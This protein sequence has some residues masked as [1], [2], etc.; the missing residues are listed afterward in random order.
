MQTLCVFT[1]MNMVGVTGRSWGS[2]WRRKAVQEGYADIQNQISFQI[3]T[4]EFKN[5]V[6]LT[7]VVFNI[8]QLVF[9]FTA[10]GVYKPPQRVFPPLVIDV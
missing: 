2:N 6:N 7:Q 9:E 3:N 8:R 10:N 4:G 1:V 5:C